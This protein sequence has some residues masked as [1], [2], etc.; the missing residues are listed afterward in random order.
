MI[1]LKLKDGRLLQ[2]NE[3]SGAVMVEGKEDKDWH[4]AFLQCGSDEP[5]FFGF[6]DL[7]HKK[8]YDIYGNISDIK[9]EDDIKL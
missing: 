8:C 5:D 9:D 6:I 4:P 2:Y 3:D 7:K 1:E